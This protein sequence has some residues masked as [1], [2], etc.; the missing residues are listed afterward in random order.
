MTIGI[1]IALIVLFIIGIIIAI[2]FACKSTRK[3]DVSY[4]PKSKGDMGENIV[5]NIL[6][7]TIE[8]QQYVINGL[9]YK[10]EY[11][12]EIDHIVINKY[13]I[14]VIET[15]NY[16]GYIYGNE[17]EDIWKQEKTN[18][19][20]LFKNPVNQ[21]FGHITALKKD[22][23]IDEI[24]HNVVVFLSC[25]NILNVFA[26]NVYTEFELRSVINTDTGIRLS[27]QEMK[28]YYNGILNLK[29]MYS[30]SKEEHKRN[31]DIANAKI[32]KG[33]CP[34]CGGKL[35]IKSGKYGRF[36]GCTNYP[37]C[38]FRKNIQD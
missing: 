35:E 27:V 1:I 26:K 23:N 7:D 25:G 5:A 33:I 10:K 16:N 6:G 17:N 8:G 19:T 29:K 24:F 34:D 13:G 14:W 2:V 15:K 37:N 11:S 4:P 20:K 38:K 30:I 21:N 36:Y 31:I 32:H 3:S 12:C 9:C 22:L 18:E 28:S